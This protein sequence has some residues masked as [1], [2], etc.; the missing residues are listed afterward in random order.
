MDKV[1]ANIKCKGS[2]ERLEDCDIELT[3]N[4]PGHEVCSKAS[5]V[6]G[7]ICD[8]SKSYNEIGILGQAIQVSV[9]LFHYSRSIVL[10]TY[11][12]L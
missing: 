6:A 3:Q 1:V 12:S 8:S 5:S 9:N 11:N 4:H 7:V 10:I 2:E